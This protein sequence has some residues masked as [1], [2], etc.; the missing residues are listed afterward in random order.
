MQQMDSQVFNNMFAQ[1]INDP[2]LLAKA[3]ATTGTWIRERVLETSF[4][5]EIITCNTITQNELDISETDDEPKKLAFIEPGA[6]AATVNFRGDTSTKWI[7]AEKVFIPFK[8]I[9]TTKYQKNEAELLGYRYPIT[10]VFEDK[11]VKA[12][13][14]QKDYS[15]ITLT[16]ECITRMGSD[17]AATVSADMNRDTIAAGLN[18][19]ANYELN[20]GTILMSL[21]DWNIWNTAKAEDVGNDI[22]NEMTSLGYQKKMITGTKAIVTN[23]K[24][25]VAPGT[26]Y[27]FAPADYLGEN[28][29]LAD[30]KFEIKKDTDIIS[31]VAWGYYGCAILNIRGA[32]KVTLPALSL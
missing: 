4:L 21:R 1:A 24:D 13:A 15:F 14:Y 9:Q 6:T 30:V 32:V 20:C 31:M 29:V 17:S 16:N 2:T 3:A 12:I 23:K 5:D 19:L 28:Y 22:A 7:E 25:Y 10:Q 26:L 18:L 11:M 27:F 8:K